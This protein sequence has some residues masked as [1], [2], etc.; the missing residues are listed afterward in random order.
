[1]IEGVLDRIAAV[2]LC[3][4]GFHQWISE[5]TPQ[6]DECIFCGVSYQQWW[7]AKTLEALDSKVTAETGSSFRRR[8]ACEEAGHG[9]TERIVRPVCKCGCGAE[10]V[11]L[12][13]VLCRDFVS[14]D[15]GRCVLSS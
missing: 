5:P 13:C 1:M 15:I 11:A 14:L 2:P 9:T 10:A 4:N 7:L 12:R 8:I 6:T 3:A